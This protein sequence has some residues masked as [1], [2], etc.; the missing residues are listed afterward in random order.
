M[1]TTEIL[2]RQCLLQEG[3]KNHVFDEKVHCTRNPFYYIKLLLNF[4]LLPQAVMCTGM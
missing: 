3:L 4:V 1:Y 2:A